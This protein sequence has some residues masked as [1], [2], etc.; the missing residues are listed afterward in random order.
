VATG[1]LLR[2]VVEADVPVFYE[3][4]LDP[5]AVRMAAFPSREKEAFRAHW[6]RILSNP[7]L[8]R[9]TILHQ[10]NVAGY[11]CCFEQGGRRQIGYW[12]GREHWGKG[13]ATG[14]LIR[15]LEEFEERPLY[16]FVAEHNAGSIRVLE[17]CG[18]RVCSEEEEPREPSPDEVVEILY[19]LGE[20]SR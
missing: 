8:I 20:P 12:I 19:R 9:K 15:F 4:Q 7:A 16:A 3:H 13:I 5:E 10:G 2:D 6:E 14:S 18:F 17:K 1:I 11:I